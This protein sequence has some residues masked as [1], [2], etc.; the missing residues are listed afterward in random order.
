[1]AHTK[2]RISARTNT[3]SQA[4]PAGVKVVARTVPNR[5]STAEDTA[6]GSTMSKPRLGEDVSKKAKALRNHE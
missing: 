4:A 2:A 5:C 1:M 3:A 6:G